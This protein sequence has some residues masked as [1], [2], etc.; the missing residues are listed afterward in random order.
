MVAVG[1]NISNH[2]IDLAQTQLKDYGLEDYKLRIFQGA[3]SDS[4]LLLANANNRLSAAPENNKRI[5]EQASR[6]QHLEAQLQSYTQY[7]TMSRSIIG[8]IQTLW[9]NIR[10]ISLSQTLEVRADSLS[11]T[12]SNSPATPQTSNP[13]MVLAVV[14][15]SG[16]F[17]ESEKTR[18]LQWLQARTKVQHLQLILRSSN[19]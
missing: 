10:S 3:Q 13:P 8:E 11:T 5:V 4:L 18:L 16:R 14:S 6:I 9:P 2:D 15:H 1:N 12:V 19:E 7:E 17:S